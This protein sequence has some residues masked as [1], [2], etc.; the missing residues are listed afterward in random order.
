MAD[1]VSSSKALANELMEQHSR[2]AMQ[3]KTFE[4]VW[5]DIEDRI[6]PT[7][8]QFSNDS[9][10]RNKGQQRTEKVFDATPGLALDRFKAAISSLVTP[11]N[12]M[13]AS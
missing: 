13:W 9:P 2:L 4:R 11:R 12:Q 10:D 5:Q 1:D 8:V 7:D 6:N 3:R